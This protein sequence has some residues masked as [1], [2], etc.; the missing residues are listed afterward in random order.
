MDL[1]FS[2]LRVR[3]LEHGI[4]AAPG[5]ASGVLEGGTILGTLWG[6]GEL[7]KQLFGGTNFRPYCREHP[8]GGDP[9]SPLRT[10]CLGSAGQP[11]TIA[12]PFLGSSGAS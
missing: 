2:S 10:G 3:P 5:G 1:T 7:R 11:E 4:C 8:I 6:S 12:N 9:P